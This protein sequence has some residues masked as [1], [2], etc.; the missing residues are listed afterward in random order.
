MQLFP[1]ASPVAS[2]EEEVREQPEEVPPVAAT[3]RRLSAAGGRTEAEG[4]SP[5]PV[6][7]LLPSPEEPSPVGPSPVAAEVVHARAW[8]HGVAEVF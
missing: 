6:G 4:P 7:P 2:G 1:A 5:S 3:A 8:A